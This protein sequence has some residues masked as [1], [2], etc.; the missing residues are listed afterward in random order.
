MF[1]FIIIALFC[2]VAGFANVR[3]ISAQSFEKEIRSGKVL[4]DF[5]GPWCGPCK[6]LSPV[7]DQLSEEMEGKVE[8]VKVNIDKAPD[9]TDK[10]TVQG[11]PT[12]ILFENGKEKGRLVGFHDKTAVKRFIETGKS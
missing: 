5:Y 7:L 8:I 3:E 11:V 9:L 10:Y 6:R 4:V 2:S 1:R 12:V